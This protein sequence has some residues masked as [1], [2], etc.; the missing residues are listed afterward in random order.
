MRRQVLAGHWQSGTGPRFCDSLVVHTIDYLA[1]F[2]LGFDAI[3]AG[4]L[5]KVGEILDNDLQAVVLN[6]TNRFVKYR[7]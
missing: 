3:G 7:A 4:P 1:E 5:E 2:R 6:F